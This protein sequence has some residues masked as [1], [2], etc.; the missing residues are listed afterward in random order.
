[1]HQKPFLS[2]KTS[3]LQVYGN[4]EIVEGYS[5]QIFCVE[6]N[7]ICWKNIAPWSVVLILLFS[8]ADVFDVALLSLKTATTHDTI[9]SAG[10]ANFASHLL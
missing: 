6:N 7:S 2:L 8:L 3:L 10:V 5:S 9:L 4:I 1:M